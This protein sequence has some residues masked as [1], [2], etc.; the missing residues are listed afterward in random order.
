[1]GKEPD[2]RSLAPTLCEIFGVRRPALC[3]ADPIEDIV[4]SIEGSPAVMLVVLDGFGERAFEVLGSSCPNFSWIYGEHSM[5]LRSV[6]PPKTPVAFSSIATGVARSVHGIDVKTDPLDAETIFDIF[7]QNGI[8]TCVA[9][10]KSGSPAHLFADLCRYTAIAESNLDKDVL[11][12]TL[13]ILEDAQ[14]QFTMLQ[15][16][17]IDKASHSSGPFGEEASRAVRGSDWRLGALMKAVA[18]LDGSMIVCSDH[19]QHEVEI[20]ENG[21]RV[22][23]KHDGSS[24]WDFLIPLGWC[25]SAELKQAAKDADL[26]TE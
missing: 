23:G 19:G 13:E 14:P 25:S 21:V 3:R 26:G 6:H 16:L 11:G 20:P 4:K 2:L 1:M 22:K 17:D 12:L 18:E 5:R 24:E 9:G 8:S 15:F 10:R 7:S